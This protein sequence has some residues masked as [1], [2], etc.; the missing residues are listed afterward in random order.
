MS[1]TERKLGVV[2]L[3][4]IAVMVFTAV[5]NVALVGGFPT[6]AG[7]NGSG[8]SVGTNGFVKSDMNFDS[9]REQYLN[10]EL[11]E[12]NTA[13]YDG[14]RWIIVQLEGESLYDKYESS[15]RY[16]DFAAYSASAEGKKAQANMI[17]AHSTFLS[18]LDRH[19]I[20]YTFKYSYTSV[21]NAVGIKV[22]AQAFNAIQ[23]MS[24]VVGVFYSESYA[25]PQVAVTNNAN[26]Y[27]TGIYDSSDLDYKGEGM[28]VAV[29]DTGLDHTH[30]AFQTPPTSPKWDEAYIESVVAKG[31]LNAN[32]AAEDFYYSSKVPFAYDYADDD[33]NVYPSYSSHGTHV[34]GIVAGSSDYV[35]NEETGEKFIGV[36]PEAQL[37]F[38]KVFT[39][40]LDS[41]ALGGA[42][43]LDILAALNDCTQLGVDVINM[44][45]GSSA[46]FSDE[47]SDAYLN[48]IY[49]RIR[50]AG[51][52]LIV[53]ASNDYSSGFGGGNGTNLSSNP[54]SGTV[55]APSTYPSALSVASINGQ[56]S[57]YVSTWDEKGVAFITKSSDQYGVELEFI[58]QL[59]DIASRS[60][61]REVA[62]GE[63]L[64]FK[65]VLITGVGRPMN[66]TSTVKKKLDHNSAVKE[67]YDGTIALVQRGDN[68]FAEKVQ[69]A[70]G[71]GADACIIYNNIAG[72][73]RMSLGD[74]EN[75]IPTCSITMDA[76][77]EFV[78]QAKANNSVGE[79]RVNSNMEAGPFMSD[80]SSWGPT[81]S[82]ELKPEITAHGGEITSAVP[83]GYDKYSGTSMAAP[84]M[85]G[86]VALLRQYLQ[87]SNPDL[88]G[89]ALNARVNQVLM[90]TATIANNENG[91]PYSPRKQGAGLAGIADAI[92]TEGFITVLD[93]GGN[94]RDK[95]KIELFDDPDKT[96]VYELNFTMHNLTDTI[97]TY[98]PTVY[99]MTETMSTDL[100]TVAE[101]AYMLNDMCSIEYFTGKD[102]NSLSSHNGTV[103]VPA[104][105]TLAVRVKITLGTQAREYLDK[106][107]ENG[108]Y[109]EGFVSMVA[110][111][112]TKVTL[113]L[114][115]LGF[116]GDWT[117]APLFDYDTYE[118]AESEKDTNVP[119]EDKLKASAAE[120]RVLGMY[121]DDQ[122]ILPMGSYI[123]TQNEEE[124]QI[125]PE[126]EKIALSIYDQPNA[127]TIY[128]LYMVY[129]G[130][131]RCAAYM[132]IVITDAAT[133]EVVFE[134]TQENIGKSYAA[135]GGNRGASIRLEIR[136]DEWGLSNNATY[137]VS[138][139]GSLDYP[140][141]EDSELNRDS[142]DFQ[143]TVDYEEPQMLGYKIRYVP[144]TENRVTKYRIWMDVDVYDNQYVQSVLPCY[145]E[146]NK[147]GENVLRL[148]TEYPIPVYGQ[149][150]EISTVSFDV[151]DI[152]D[153]YV[154][155]GKLY[156][157]VEDYAMNAFNYQ[158]LPGSDIGGTDIKD[159]PESVDFAQ[160]AN[161]KKVGEPSQDA[162]GNTFNTYELQLEPFT[163][164]KLNAITTPATSLIQTLSW[165]GTTTRIKAQ[166]DEI[167]VGQSGRAELTLV[168]E[169]GNTYA[170]VKVTVSGAPTA[171]MPSPESIKLSAVRNGDGYVV[172]LDG[173]L[174]VL[175]LNPNQK[176]VRLNWTISPWYCEAPPV[177]W[178]SSNDSI[179][180]VDNY[181][182]ITAIKRGTAYVSVTSTLNERITKS[183]RIVVGDEFD[184]RNYTL[185]EYYG[186][187]EVVIPNDRNIMYLDEDCFKGNTEI[188]KVTLPTS[189]TEIPINAFK[190]CTNLTEIVIPG[191]C[192]TIREAAFDGCAS[193]QKVTLGMFVNADREELGDEYFGT[194]TLGRHAFRG[195]TALTTIENQ[196]RLTT[197]NQG[198]FEG[199]T[200]L[201]EIDLS[202]VRVVGSEVFKDCTN[203]SVV[204]TSAATQIGEYM[205][206]G[207]TNLTSFEFKG[208]SIAAHAFADCSKLADFTIVNPV[209]SIGEGA[210]TNTALTQI[211][212]PDGDIRLAANSFADCVSLAKVTLGANTKLIMGS[213]SPFVGCNEFSQYELRG[214]S[215]HYSV[216]DGALYSK[217]GKV[218]ISVPYAKTTV[219][220]QGVTEIAESAFA[221][222]KLE[223]LDLSGVKTV[224]EY[225]FANSGLKN[226]V[227][228]AGLTEIPAGLFDGCS[229][230]T[231]VTAADNFAALKSIGANAFRG[232]S[233]LRSVAMPEVTYVGAHAFENSGITAA[234]SQKITE[235]GIGAFENSALA[236]IDLPALTSIGARAFANIT[237]LKSVSVGA[238][239]EMG[240][241]VFVGSKN[242][243]VATF[244]E[245]TTIIGRM[246]FYSEDVSNA[247]IVI[248][249]PNTVE[250]IGAAAFFN[251]KK[252]TTINLSGVKYVDMQAFEN[253]GLAE[254]DLSNIIEIGAEAFAFSALTSVNLD[255]AEII[256]MNAFR[257]SESLA[258]VTLGSARI[259][260]DYAFT[261]TALTTVTI[262][263]TMNSRT[264]DYE[265]D[266]LDHKNRVIESKTRKINAYGAGA[267]SNIKNLKEI[268]VAEGNDVFKSIDGVLYSVS[269]DGL[270]LE[271]Y[272]TVKEGARYTVESNTVAIGNSAFD[273]VKLLSRVELPYTVKSI[274]GYAFFESS[275]TNY[276]FN[277]VNAPVLLASFEGELYEN[278]ITQFNANFG[279]FSVFSDGSFVQSPDD[280][281]L[282]MTVPLNSKG[283]DAKL[284]KVFFSTINYTE[285]IVPE[286]ITHKAIESIEVLKAYV[287]SIATMTLAEINKKG[288]IGELA[289][290]ARSAYN[291]VTS[292]EQLAFITD[293]ATLLKVEKSLRDRK[294]A[295]G[296]PVLAAGL[297][298]IQRPDK[299]VYIEGETFDAKGMVIVVIYEDGSRVEL[300][301]DSYVVTPEVLSYG[302]YE[303]TVTYTENGKSVSINVE[304]QVER[305]PNAGTNPGG[306]VN[307]GLEKTTVI[308]IAVCVPV[309]VLIVAGVTVLLLLR[310]KKTSPKTEEDNSD[311]NKKSENEAEVPQ[312]ETA[313]EEVS[314][315]ENLQGESEAIAE[316]EQ[317]AAETD[318]EAKEPDFEEATAEIPTADDDSEK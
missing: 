201:R 112:N 80:F 241:N 270:V 48:G 213:R 182:R 308:A 114:P 242:I 193:L 253:T 22:D 294:A 287:D 317:E 46:G 300:P 251:L 10:H 177:K 152:Y 155:T 301:T 84:N 6:A 157:Q 111:G 302:M 105:S 61:G 284:W 156:L 108:M 51:I 13:S 234:P 119:P 181:G 65:Y 72:T 38:C 271:Q 206:A 285:E 37:V 147:S 54:D 272:P 199:C 117:D 82:L 127:R 191:Q 158:I 204:K 21:T 276:T 162:N 95:T 245:G 303:V 140:M 307:G 185:Y 173:D 151:T 266:I 120:T 283:Y 222:I 118:L 299:S 279:Y 31:K 144:Y 314:K 258:S 145:I 134:Q 313:T 211:A 34:A 8:S 168:D 161:L 131:L 200:S 49:N 87:K 39:D 123:Y 57:A 98:K 43:T 257:K 91:N 218:I 167:F 232:C 29:L 141:P 1:K 160:D 165:R 153:D 265:W 11:V 207:C 233:Q 179:V 264:Y 195:C 136:P 289:A 52:S 125:Y 239:T 124:V 58:E 71:G 33:C 178:E 19:G 16:N 83:G 138:L 25:V 133:G 106:N 196:T 107:F 93:N 236:A 176:D 226:V 192:T 292:A 246:A 17:A 100:K 69:A 278:G 103:E 7:A 225:A 296:A 249:L 88:T 139:K 68:T 186:G 44:S 189:L 132:D 40:D 254:A 198:A 142:F 28:V 32:G 305:D 214:A 78:E 148:V 150:G 67:G 126:R 235:V 316:K 269:E 220:M 73:I 104:N 243:T 260:G 267:F 15:T 24:G 281:G 297:E 66:Y 240:D 166:S 4:L 310:K 90:S 187:G 159:Y 290:E 227:L 36:A 163:L 50:E 137:N 256:G 205:F 277:S 35:V 229:A 20:D 115:Y 262:P 309:A 146:T 273:S 45:L 217:D 64:K 263:E 101:K 110:N 291:A 180:Q 59:Y 197:L 70:M 9:I 2:S 209:S 228:P 56:K 53:A 116:Y 183:V 280:L 149:K 219:D 23:K 164:Y 171:S 143:F 202:E 77:V 74:V 47:K 154:K 135:G 188:T 203:L 122:Y 89:P 18:K 75:P 97:Q 215:N 295:L 79:L 121:F 288:G 94:V 63:T 275:V 175:E 208:Q 298:R 174:P 113:G 169:F 62:L 86:A 85:A 274:G 237:E 130:L 81:P 30:E 259:I 306:T 76:A 255:K 315:E 318:A 238:I 96:G 247:Q 312:E 224:G 221:G 27:T 184:V 304:V 12:K 60:R 293:Y 5:F 102:A 170:K 250:E 14:D 26:V 190:G 230:L 216:K 128:E 286:D 244:A 311:E 109:I 231:S 261:G 268:K 252:L 212:L 194:I 282:T 92:N 129:A 99:V 172:S 41:D 210:F 223:S 3:I 55:G 248:N 42:D